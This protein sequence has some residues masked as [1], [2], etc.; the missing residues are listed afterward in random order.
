MTLHFLVLEPILITTGVFFCAFV[1]FQSTVS[2]QHQNIETN[3][4]SDPALSL[5][6]L[7]KKYQPC[8]SCST[9]NFVVCFARYAVNVLRSDPIVTILLLLRRCLFLTVDVIGKFVSK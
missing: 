4:G 2:K 1:L 5:T 9:I 3:Q 6:R 8:M 7:K